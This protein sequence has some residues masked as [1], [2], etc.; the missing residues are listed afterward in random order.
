ML[1]I[2]LGAKTSIDTL[3]QRCTVVETRIGVKLASIDFA[4]RHASLLGAVE[5][6][7]TAGSERGADPK[8]ARLALGDTVAVVADH[9]G[10]LRLAP[11]GGL[12]A[13]VSAPALRLEL[14]MRPSPSPCPRSPPTAA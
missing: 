11:E 8:R 13:Q 9:V 5:A 2:G 6:T 4:A 14:R 3:G 10:L 1:G 12:A 7:L